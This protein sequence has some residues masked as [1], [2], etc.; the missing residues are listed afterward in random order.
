MLICLNT[1]LCAGTMLLMEERKVLERAVSCKAALDIPPT[2]RTKAEFLSSRQEL[3][4]TV[5]LSESSGRSGTW[6]VWQSSLSL[7]CKGAR[8]QCTR[9]G[10]H[11]QTPQRGC[12]SSRTNL[13]L[14][15]CFSGRGQS[16]AQL[17]PESL[18]KWNP[19]PSMDFRCTVPPAPV[20]TSGKIKELNR[21]VLLCATSLCL[22]NQMKRAHVGLLWGIKFRGNC[23]HFPNKQWAERKLRPHNNPWI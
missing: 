21:K 18:A 1:G 5:S 16:W 20:Q 13:Q 15:C 17:P 14:L 23:S 2:R 11:R 6:A 12:T 9:S 10:K 8:C 3:L 22:Q 7:C 4:S 19:L